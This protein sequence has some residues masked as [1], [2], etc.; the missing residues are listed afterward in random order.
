MGDKAV[1]DLEQGHGNHF[2]CITEES[3]RD[4]LIKRLPE[5]LEKAKL[6]VPPGA[7]ISCSLGEE[8]PGQLQCAMLADSEEDLHL[9]M[10]IGLNINGERN[11]LISF[12]PEMNGAEIPV[13]LTTIHEW[14]NGLEATLEGTICNGEHNIAFFD[15]RY[16]AHKGKYKIGETYAFRIAA[17]AG[18]CECVENPTFK[19]EGQQAIDFKAKLGEKPDYD[20]DGNVKPLVFDM[21]RMVAFFQHSVAYPHVAEFQSPIV[22][23]SVLKAWNREYYS[24]RIVIAHDEDDNEIRVPLVA[25]KTFFKGELGAGLPIR[26]IAYLMGFLP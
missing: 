10:L 11:E 6:T 5:M 8:Y 17:L 4:E 2:D 24:I 12:Y 1:F 19:F 22:D 23:V 16:I 20:E 26:G 7:L 18:D 25:K 9:N 13:T 21:S 15:T 3:N 14:G